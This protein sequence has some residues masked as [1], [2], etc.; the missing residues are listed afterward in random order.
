MKKERIERIKPGTFNVQTI[1]MIQRWSVTPWNRK[2]NVVWRRWDSRTT[3]LGRNILYKMLEW[4]QENRRGR[5]TGVE[6]L[7]VALPRALSTPISSIVRGT[8][9]TTV[10][11]FYFNDF[12]SSFWLRGFAREYRLQLRELPRMRRSVN[13]ISKKRDLINDIYRGRI[14]WI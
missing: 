6:R 5:G 10:T 4:K 9:E 12:A 1:A 13:S 11:V 14:H 7:S 2:R 3:R 8:N